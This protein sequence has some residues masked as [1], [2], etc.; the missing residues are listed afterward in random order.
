MKQLLQHIR[1]GETEIAEIPCPRSKAKHLLIQTRASL[2]SAGTE[3]MLIEFSRASLVSKARQNPDRVRQVL[4]KIKADGLLPTMEAVFARLEEPIPLGYCNAGVVVEVGASVTEFRVGDRVASNG[5]H[6]EMVNVPVNLC[7]KIPAGVSD[8]QAA[9]SVVGSIGL[10]GIRLIQPTLGESVAVFGL[11]LIGLVAVQLL[12]ASGCRVLGIDKNADRLRLAE[13]FGAEV[14]DVSG[15]ADPV[16]EAAAVSNG[17][18]VDAVLITASAKGNAIVHQAAQMS[19][20]RGRI[21]LVGVVGLKLERADF[22][23]KELSFQVSCSYGPGRYDPTY[24][25]QGQD[26]PYGFVRWTQQRNLGAVLDMMATGRLDMGPLIT[27]RIPL[28]DAGRAYDALMK[29]SSAIGI[30]LDYPKS[31][32]PRRQTVTLRNREIPGHDGRAVI[33][34]IGAGQYTRAFMLP[35]L[36]ATPAVLHTIA[37]SGGVTGAQL[38]GKFGFAKTTTDYRTLLDDG[39]IN[40]VVITTRHDLHPAMIEE[41]LQAGKHVHVEKPVA[42]DRAGFE[43]VRSAIEAAEDRV[44]MVGFNRRFSPHVQK[45]HELLSTRT[46]PLCMAC[47]VNAGQVPMNHWAQNPEEGGGRIL[48]EGCHWIDLMMFLARAPVVAV[49]ASQVGDAP[50]QDTPTDKTSITLRFGDGSIG[51]L[52]YFANGHRSYAKEKL[53]VFSEGRILSLDNFRLL[54]GHGFAGFRAHKLMRKDKGHR[55]MVARFIDAIAK[56]GPPPMPL[57]GIYNVTEAS[58]AA[59]EAAASGQ[60]VSLVGSSPTEAM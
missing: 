26:Y 15:D 53:D 52:H 54:R 6:A 13:Q 23:E 60:T 46:Q 9:F 4:D 12:R 3:R 27:N 44:F 29:D 8:E 22:Y 30:V 16:A 59:V 35:S 5:A 21:V 32:P 55:A 58:F 18:G 45:M 7:A 34:L 11:G 24:E 47:V 28:G 51:T 36:A 19:R 17:Q 20:K 25:E 41:A 38:A 31:E 10:Q 56:G 43:R 50:G 2:I 42:I 33:G 49:H 37:S 1:S 48:G 57:D 40:A 39:D 14:V